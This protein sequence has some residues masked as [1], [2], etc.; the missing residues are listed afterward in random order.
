MTELAD[1]E[2]DAREALLDKAEEA[3]YAG[4]DNIMF[5]LLRAA[6]RN[7]DDYAGRNDYDIGDIPAS[8]RVTETARGPR[9]VSATLEWEHELT[10]LFEF[11]VSPH[12]IEGN[13][14]LSFAWPSPPEGTRP[15]GAPGYVE[16][17]SVNW[18]SVTGGIPESRAIRGA[19]NR[20]RFEMQGGEIRL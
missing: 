19:L 2:D 20:L 8:G 4:P 7:W 6:N 17:E 18:G 15:Q 3:L 16:T 9:S 5:Q 10:A 11:G 14:L 13:P 1:F 12:K